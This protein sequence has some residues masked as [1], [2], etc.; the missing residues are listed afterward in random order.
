VLTEQ[1]DE[2][3]EGRRYISLELLT[4]SRIRIVS[5]TPTRQTSPP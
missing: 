5:P 3:I 1:S 2:W 4:K